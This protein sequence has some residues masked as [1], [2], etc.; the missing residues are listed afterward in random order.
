MACRLRSS[1]A[2]CDRGVRRGPEQDLL[3][4]DALTGKELWRHPADPERSRMKPEPY[5]LRLTET[6]VLAPT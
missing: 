5:G 6:G 3:G 1:C 2:V 4:L